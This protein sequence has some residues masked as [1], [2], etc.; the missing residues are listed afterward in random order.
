MVTPKSG[1]CFLRNA[2]DKI[3]I[4]CDRNS[5]DEMWTNLENIDVPGFNGDVRYLDKLPSHQKAQLSVAE[6][7]GS[8]RVNGVSLRILVMDFNF[9]DASMGFIVGEKITR[10]MQLHIGSR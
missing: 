4:L 5:F 9:P 6:I 10:T 1:Y 7:A 8:A 3:E 2:H